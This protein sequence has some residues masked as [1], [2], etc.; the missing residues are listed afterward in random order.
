MKSSA[1][2]KQLIGKRVTYLKQEDVDD[3]GR[4]LTRRYGTLTDIYRKHLV[5]DGDYI[6][7]SQLYSIALREDTQP[8]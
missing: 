6:H 1:E 5:I 2:L 3:F 8:K 4:S 7:P